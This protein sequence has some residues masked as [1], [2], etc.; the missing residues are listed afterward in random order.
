MSDRP[1]HYPV[2][3]ERKSILKYGKTVRIRP[4]GP[5]DEH[6]LHAF[7]DEQSM[8]ERR[9]WFH[10]MDVDDELL[11]RRMCHASEEGYGITLLVIRGRPPSERI[12]GVG[13]CLTD[14]DPHTGEIAFA[15]R[16]SM[17]GE[18]IGTLLLERLALHA[19]HM[20]I[21]T[22]RAFTRPDNERM[23]GVFQN[24]GFS[25]DTEQEDG[26]VHVEMS[27]HP[28]PDQLES[29]DLRDR[30]ATVASLQPFFQPNGVAVIGA[31]RDP[32]SIGYRVLKSLVDNNFQGPVYPVNPKADVIHSMHV[33]PNIKEVPQQVDLAVIVVPAEKCLQVVEDCADAGVRGV[34]VVTAGFAETGELGQRRQEKLLEAVRGSGMRMI[35]P[36]CLGLLN[37]K[38]SVSLNASFSPVFPESGSLAMLSHSGAFG[39]AIL[40]MAKEH[41]MGLSSFVSVGN[42]PDVSGND[43]LQYWESDQSTDV[44][45]LYLESFGNPR[46]FSRIARRIS[47]KKPIIAVKGGQT[48][49]GER[50]VSSHTANLAGNR[51][52]LEALF[53]Q[54]GVLRAASLENMFDLAAALA[55]QPLPQGRR[56]GIVTNAGGPG[57]LCADT[58][59]SNHLEIPELD[60]ET[61]DRLREVLPREASLVNPVDMVASAGPEEYRECVSAVMESPNID[62]VIVLY[63]PVS[64]GEVDKTLDFI[65]QGISSARE[66]HPDKPVMLCQVA[67]EHKSLFLEL[68]QERVPTYEF[69]ETPAHLIRKMADYR[70][71]LE[72]PAGEIPSFDVYQQ[73]KVKKWDARLSSTY[74]DQWLP[75]DVGRELLQDFDFPLASGRVVTSADEAGEVAAEVGFPVAAKLASTEVIHKTEEGGVKLDLKSEE[76]VANAYRQMEEKFGAT[77]ADGP[78][79]GMLVQEMITEGLEIIIGVSTDPKFGH[80]ISFGLGGIFVEV[81]S[82]VTFRM[83]PLTDQDA[84]EML[85]EIRGARLLDGYRGQPAVDRE[86]LENLL[87]RVSELTQH[88]PRVQEMDFNPVFAR[89]KGDGCSIV[90]VRIHTR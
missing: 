50:A 10:T 27:V 70:E 63:I 88:M 74:E 56:I 86:A 12:L 84:R 75:M 18:G 67:D 68:E 19:A 53:K 79:N 25:V 76:E 85:D 44:I 82:D 40:S 42:K 24:S 90:D 77:D 8:E 22:F 41:S 3:R 6:D 4:A 71:W 46:R 45:L 52:G 80:L 66:E 11:A 26:Y 61:K 89:T 57:I 20:G 43:L 36:N 72:K 59:E 54:T 31:S 62:A 87:L 9:R 37:P 35:G 47:R 48:E 49:A 14:E 81:M 55:N 17:R 23:L 73:D 69:P 29:F 60:E 38:P 83:A 33:Y 28:R 30:V 58:C 65:G 2:E 13:S 34:I 21:R 1:Q 64:E 15:V 32:T 39:L 16:R 5:S 7:F 51:A 78:M